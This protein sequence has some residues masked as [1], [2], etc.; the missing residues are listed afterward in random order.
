MHIRISELNPE[1]KTPQIILFNKIKTKSLA[2]STNKSANVSEARALLEKMV[3][4]CLGDDGVGLAAPQ[5]N[6]F[7][8]LFIIREMDTD[9]KPLESFIGYFNPEWKAVSEYGKE[10]GIEQ[11]HHGVLRT[12][13][14]KVYRHPVFHLIGVECGRV[15]VGTAIAQEIPR[16][17]HECV[18]GIRLP[19]GGGAAFRAGSV[20][21]SFVMG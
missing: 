9:N 13:R 2:W 18:H 1:T 3:K 5:I 16:R 10:T 4:A 14:V 11:V 8:Q 12:A 21:E 19:P 17:T 20:D 6:I 15:I 7:K